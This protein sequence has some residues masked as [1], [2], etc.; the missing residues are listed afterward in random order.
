MRKI[1]LLA[2]VIGALLYATNNNLTKVQTVLPNIEDNR[3][4]LGVANVAN[5]NSTELMPIIG[6]QD[7]VGYTTYDWQYNGPV[8]SHCRYCPTTGVEGLHCYWMFSN[9]NP[10]TDR[11]QRYNF[12]DFTT[13][14]WNWPNE[15][16]NVYSSRS[17]FGSFDYDPVTGCGV[18]LTHQSVGGVL[19]PVAANDIMPGGGLFQYSNGPSGY[20]WPAVAVSNNQALHVACVDATSQDSLWYTRCQPWGTWSTPIRI[21]SEGSA[22]LFPDH[23]IAASKTSNKVVILW[24]CSEDPYPERAFYRVSLDGGL[25][26]QPEVQ[27]PFPPSMYG[28]N[29]CYHISSLFAMFDNQDNLRIVA[30]VMHYEGTSGYTIPS[31]IWLYSP[32]SGNPNPWTLIHHYDADTLN[33]PVGYNATFACRP[34][35]VQAAD[36]KFYVAWEQ[37]DSLNYEPTTSLA[38]ADIWVA[39]VSNNGQTVTRK[40]RITDPNTTS[41]RFPCVGGVKDDTVFVQYVIDSV[42]G[43]EL[44]S[45]GPTTR[46]P[47]VLHRFHRNSLPAAIEEN[48]SLLTYTFSLKSISPNPTSSKTT[49]TYSIPARSYVDLTVYDILGRPIKNLVSGTQGPG[50]ATVTWDG[51]DANGDLVGHGV[52]FINLSTP[53]A[54]AS[55]KV[56]RTN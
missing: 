41:K 34:S 55:S 42:A 29:P 7:V 19:T 25:T 44:Y 50:E 40:G 33:A 13:R 56:I 49:I 46:N 26:W 52:Y 54:R 22:P 35:I 6:R 9:F 3:T 20:Q 21:H 31:Q 4:N 5:S 24:E 27:L 45:Q 39:E 38:R 23:N 11:N 30:S 28:V 18:G 14:T 1:W 10:A 53:T 51:R 2:I 17:G 12:Y 32:Q 43:F 48:S 37:F 8:Y 47:V 15:G 36:G 16:I